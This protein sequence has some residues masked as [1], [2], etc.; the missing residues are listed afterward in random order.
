MT[1]FYFGGLLSPDILFE[2]IV[3]IQKEISHVCEWAP[4]DKGYS[5]ITQDVSNLSI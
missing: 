3:L 5:E 2:H 4:T 1:A